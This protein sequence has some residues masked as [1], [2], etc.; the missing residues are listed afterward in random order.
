MSDTVITTSNSSRQLKGASFLSLEHTAKL[1]LMVILPV[2]IAM[3]LGAVFQLWTK[4]YG[5]AV[6]AIHP[7]GTLSQLTSGW[8]MGLVAA[9]LVL[10]PLLVLLEM[11]TRAEY[12]KRPGFRGR[13]AYKLPL[14]LAFASL[15]ALSLISLVHLL[16]AVLSSLTLIGVAGANIGNIYLSQFVPALLSLII[17]GLA[18]A[19]M[20]AEVKGRPSKGLAFSIGILVAS[21][22]LVLA[23][24][25][26][27]VVQL[28]T[29][30]ET[31]INNKESL[32][33]YFRDYNLNN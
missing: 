18:S 10:S 13:L 33:D 4:G 16:G 7:L 24:F 15:L 27:T 2:L 20:M 14:Y 30:R 11:R 32:Q 26:T 25:I 12:V 6:D 28:H 22:L 31:N 3:G 19:Y 17:F 1:A 23:L 5:T 21:G 8:N 29:K 9:L